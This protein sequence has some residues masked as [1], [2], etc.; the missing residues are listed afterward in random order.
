MVGSS[1]NSLRPL[2]VHEGLAVYTFGEGAPLLFMPYPHGVGVVGDPNFMA[3][4]RGLI[5]LGRRVIT[6]DPPCSGRST[7]PARLDMQEMLACAEEALTACGIM[8]PVD[9]FGHSQGGVAALAFAIE[10]PQR[11]RSLILANTASGGP[12]YFR[13]PGAIWNRSH[14]DY[15]R[16]G[17]P[18]LL[19]LLTRRHAP[20]M[21]ML[22]VIFRA[23]WFDRSRF[24]PARITLHDWF[25]PASPRLAWNLMARRL[26]YGTRLEEVRAPTLVLAGHHDPQMPPACAEELVR[27]IP[28]ARLVIF[29]KSGHYPFLE[30]P[31]LFWAAV[32]EFMSKQRSQA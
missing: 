20:A 5:K 25:R 17:L 4:I 32:E 16:M 11:V 22:N 3:L 8:A 10:Q 15:W 24:V 23:S 19:Y 14:P 30:E 21:L 28:N 1:E 6:F 31:D 13:A 12:C 9:V 18:G 26:H 27:G 29:E 7:R 2:L